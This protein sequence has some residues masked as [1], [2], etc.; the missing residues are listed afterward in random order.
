MI[1]PFLISISDAFILASLSDTPLTKKK[2]VLTKLSEPS[3]AGLALRRG[4]CLRLA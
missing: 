1:V 4:G 2:K 3:H